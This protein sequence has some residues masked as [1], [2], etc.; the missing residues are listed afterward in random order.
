MQVRWLVVTVVVATSLVATATASGFGFV[1]AW[2][3]H[4][5][6]DG[7]FESPSA[8]AVDRDGNLYVADT[9]N[10]RVQKF[11]S[12][13]NFLAKWGTA[14]TG[15]G[16]FSAPRGITVDTL[17][18]VYVADTLNSRFQQFDAATGLYLLQRGTFG[19]GPTQ[20]RY[21]V[22]IGTQTS[23]LIL[24]ADT[25][26]SR[27]FRYDSAG[28]RDLAYGAISGIVAPTDAEGGTSVDY[29]AD[30]GAGS[31]LI[32]NVSTGDVMG[33]YGGGLLGRPNSLAV[34]PG[35]AGA[36]TIWVAETDRDRVFSLQNQGAGPATPGLT[37]GT[38]GSCPGQFASPQGI[39]VTAAGEVYV[40]DTANNRIVELGPAGDPNAGCPVD[41]EPP[42]PVV[43]PPPDNNPPDTTL[44]A[45]AKVKTH[46]RKAKV[47]VT[48][49]ADEPATFTCRVDG[50]A[51][52]ACA[53]PA[54][55]KLRKGKHLIEVIATD[56]A[57][58]ADPDPP[59]A[60]VKVKRKKHK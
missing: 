24:V 11:D 59:V 38:S 47:T 27:L 17:S 13:G 1:R 29:V 41:P 32:T 46:K 7:Q 26:N 55:F 2:G 60:T 33:S 42:A 44:K 22:G 34:I 21:P 8:I 48:F 23:G 36:D 58:N 25:Q 52:G 18:Y 20:F 40:A 9:G 15:N 57:G 3:T 16:Q 10:N 19:S 43:P 28:T 6:A 4:G 39:A 50:A 30:P 45:P 49:T 53:S 35:G 14:G 5:A 31:I 56:T 54:K 37:Y 12:Q 51:L